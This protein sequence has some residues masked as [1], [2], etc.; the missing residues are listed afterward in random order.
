MPEGAVLRAVSASRPPEPVVRLRPDRTGPL[1]ALLA[2]AGP[3]LE[4][5]VD[6]GS[7]ANGD[8]LLVV[9]RPAA[10]LHE[11]L[12]TP[13]SLAAGEAV[14]VLA[15]LAQALRRMHTAGVAHGEWGSPPS[16]STRRAAP[17][18]AAPVEPVLARRVG[19]SAFDAA[20]AADV[21]A[22]RALC[23]LLLDRLG[24]A[25][26]RATDPLDLALLED[27]LFGLAAPLPV[28]LHPMAAPVQEAGPPSRLVPAVLAPAVPDHATPR[29]LLRRMGAVLPV[30][31]ASV[32]TVR[33]RA[34]IALGGAAVLLS[35]AVVALPSGDAASEE[36]P[37]PGVSTA[38][39]RTP[40]ARPDVPVDRRLDPARAIAALLARRER[41][42][43]AGSESCI[44]LVDAVASPALAADLAVIRSGADP[45][46]IDRAR[47][48]VAPSTG[49]TVL[50]TAGGA[51]VLAIREPDGWRLR[52]VVAEPPGAG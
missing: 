46:R 37:S 42:L 34:W 4:R 33:P 31:R 3:H 41:C 10:R 18:L 43:A 26:P 38:P 39:A 2:G 27:A 8:L 15:P 40:T 50:A 36:A 9:E 44:A 29:A 24:V 52:D 7:A 11:L 23:A 21:V 28:R 30:M 5:L 45:V 17:G 12:E 13:G 16:C 48:D 6:V 51:T 14:T 25:L 22:F 32:R 19:A 1:E 49:A 20:A 47:L 35:A